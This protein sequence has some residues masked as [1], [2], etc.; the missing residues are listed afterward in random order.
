MIER[1]AIAPNATE[2]LK[3]A[4]EETTD[5]FHVS[6]LV[7]H[8]VVK[9]TTRGLSFAVSPTLRAGLDAPWNGQWVVVRDFDAQGFDK[10]RQLVL[11][12]QRDL[13]CCGVVGLK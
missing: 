1:S 5:F 12:V 6:F 4:I 3:N 9:L 11:A 10:L 2:V 13:K 7:N 8:R